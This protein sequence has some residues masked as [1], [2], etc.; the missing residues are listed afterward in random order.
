MKN[1]LNTMYTLMLVIGFSWSVWAQAPISILSNESGIST[2]S[3]SQY[4]KYLEKEIN[5]GRIPGAVSLISR[6]GHMAH[7]K[8]LGYNN[9][10]NKEQMTMD[11]IFYIQSMTKPIISIAF[12]TLYEEG[13]FLL[14]DPVAQ[15]LPEF[16]DLKVM[17]PQYDETGEMTGVEYLPLESPVLIW[18]LL[19]HTA[20]FSHGLGS[21]EYDQG[22][23]KALY[24]VPYK[25]IK[26]RVA[27]LTDYPLMGQP[28]KQWNYSAAP[29]VLALLIEKF[30]GMTTADY[31]DKTIFDPL[32]MNDTGYN[33]SDANVSRVVGLHMQN[34]EGLLEPVDQWSPLNGN[35]VYG[36]THGLFS[37]AEDYMKFGE[38][39]LNNGSANGRRIIGRKTLEL[40][41]EN[42]IDGLPYGP[43][44]GFGLGFGVRTDI[45]DSKLSGSAGSFYWSGAF[46]TYFVVDQEEDLVAILMTQFWPY[47]NLYATKMRQMVYSAIED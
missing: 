26:E 4:E 18:H 43:G 3:L 16:A 11:K 45:S 30:S 24:E 7:A 35:T 9:V 42:H 46:N 5:E 20:G 2:E 29:D 22:L 40:M 39:L 1:I 37:T 28:G 31:L 34:Q 14:T 10:G 12:M 23:Y 21:N 17:T 44:N 15:Y 25:T 36:G 33:V 13:H 47:T 19:S 38:M 41:T 8:A 27:A 32:G 6:H